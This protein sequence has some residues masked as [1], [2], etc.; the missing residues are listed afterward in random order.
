MNCGDFKMK[1]AMDIVPL[2]RRKD[3]SLV[4]DKALS[5]KNVISIFANSKGIAI[6]V[7]KV[8]PV[9]QYW[10]I[11]DEYV[12]YDISDIEICREKIKEFEKRYVIEHFLGNDMARTIVN[13]P[14]YT[15]KEGET[16]A[17]WESV[18]LEIEDML[19]LV[20]VHLKNIGFGN[21][22]ETWTNELRSVN[23][24]E[25]KNNKG[26]YPKIFALAYVI[27]KAE[28]YYRYDFSNCF[29]SS[30]GIVE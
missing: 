17:G 19:F 8:Y 22:Q 21:F 13:K 14:T 11:T 9:E 28:P 30:C 16:Y 15:T 20:Q 7:V 2:G 6:L 1:V 3:G 23:L 12:T 10:Y 25:I 29:R 24:E 26:T 27:N 4:V 5:G 18:T